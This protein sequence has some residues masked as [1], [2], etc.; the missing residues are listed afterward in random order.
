MANK[1]DKAELITLLE[2]KRDEI[3][4][5]NHAK[6]AV[7]EAK[8]EEWR[9]TVVAKFADAV[10]S[11]TIDAPFA[12]HEWSYFTPP[13]RPAMNAYQGLKSTDHYDRAIRQVSAIHGDIVELRSGTD[14]TDL[15]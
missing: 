12:K 6:M 4:E 3:I 10:N 9:E 5:A 7:Y 11:T 13:S 2:T 1:Y 15:L 8:F 14:I